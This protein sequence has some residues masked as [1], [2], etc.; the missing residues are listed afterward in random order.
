MLSA[1]AG[2]LLL[3][4]ACGDPTTPR[5]GGP[6]LVGQWSAVRPAPLVQ[7]HLTLLPNGKVLSWGR[8]GDPRVWDPGTDA[9]TVVPAPSLLFCA[10]HDFLPDGRLLVAGG[11][12]SDLHGLA[13]TNVFDPAGATWQ[14]LPPM[15]AGRWYPTNTTLPNGEVLTLAGTDSSGAQVT[16]PEVWDGT[17]W[18]QLTGASLALS[19]YPRTFVAPDGRVFYAGEEQLSRYLDVTGAGSW[20]NGPVRRFGRR[21]YGSAVMYEPGKILYAGGGD[22]PTNT[23]ETIDLNN[24]NPTWAYTG[25][26]AHARRQMNA[27]LLPTGDVLVTGGTAD[28]GFSNPA[29]AVYDAELWTPATGRWTTLAGNAVIRI[30]HQ[31][32]I[33]LPDGHVLNTGS[34]GATGAVDQLN[35]ELYSPPYFFKGPRPTITGATPGAVTYGQTLTVA[36]PDGAAI[37]QVTLIRLGSVTHAFDQSQ[38]L[39]PLGFTRVIGGV[40]IT[41]PAGGAT[42]PPGPY[43]LFLVNGSGAPS[44]GRIM[45]LH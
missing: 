24:A 13:N 16:I 18:R 41:L 42:A 4:H 11:H 43:M 8:V 45:L 29:G 38:R 1:V 32:T 33:L 6:P 31:T 30:Y 3:L 22:P 25:S 28:T 14:A 26:M 9:F 10:G 44:V 35:Y 36:S 7:I 12:I 2:G 20:S 23:A 40:S 27:T 37:T 15:A 17:A 19:Y 39:V 5:V 21:D 34:G